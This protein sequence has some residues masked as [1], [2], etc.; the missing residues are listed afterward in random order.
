VR[1]PITRFTGVAV[2]DEI[3]AAV[4]TAV[5]VRSNGPLKE[6]LQEHETVKL[7][8]DPD[9]SLFLHPE[10]MIFFALNVTLDATLTFA[11][12]VTTLR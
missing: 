3:P 9:A 10:I 2:E 12:I 8:P 1:L 5:A 11:V 4:G 6:G 7:E